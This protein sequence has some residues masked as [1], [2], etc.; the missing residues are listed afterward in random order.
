M[1]TYTRLEIGLFIFLIIVVLMP[2]GLILVVA[3]ESP[4]HMVSGEPV[5][6]AAQATGI[7]VA[8]VRD[9]TWN[10][11]GAQGGKTYVLTDNAG[12]TVTVSTQSFDSADS[13]D[14]AVRLHYAQQVGRSKPVGSLV[15][16][17]QH[18]IYVTPANSNILERLAPILK[19][20][21]SP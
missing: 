8:S 19:Q 7:T 1:S 3:E 20:K 12:E 10:L 15:V 13:R 2:L 11:P 14:A 21:I 5:N 17:G 16:I 9:S 18:L 4:Y 6:E